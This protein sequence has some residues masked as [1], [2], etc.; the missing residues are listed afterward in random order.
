MEK[1]KAP[2]LGSWEALGNSG[3]AS[4]L[5]GLRIA[6]DQDVMRSH[7]WRTADF[8]FSQVDWSPLP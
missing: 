1:N 4:R 3:A 6:P 7:P 8:I 2:Q 5:H